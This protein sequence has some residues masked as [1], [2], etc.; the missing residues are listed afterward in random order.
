MKSAITPISTKQ[1]I[2]SCPQIVGLKKF[3]NIKCTCV[4]EFMNK[5]S[6][7]ILCIKK[8]I[9]VTIFCQ[10]FFFNN[11]LQK[12]ELKECNFFHISWQIKIKW[13]HTY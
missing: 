4:S 7:H 2:P 9:I 8:L 3:H 11:N 6:W 10:I 1:T 5:H 12:Q 13:I